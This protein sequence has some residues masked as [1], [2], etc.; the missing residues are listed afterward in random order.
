M[1]LAT[2]WLAGALVV[3]FAVAVGLVALVYYFGVPR[4]PMP[5]SVGTP[6]AFVIPA[7]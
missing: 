2:L 4:A 7:R 3:L 5:G 1:G 6:H